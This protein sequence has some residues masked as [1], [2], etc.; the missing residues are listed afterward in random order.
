MTG[1][2]RRTQSG[3]PGTGSAFK[4]IDGGKNHSVNVEGAV[5]SIRP[6]KARR[7]SIVDYRQRLLDTLRRQSKS[8][9]YGWFRPDH[10][11]EL[12]DLALHAAA[13]RRGRFVWFG[14]I[15]FPMRFGI[16]K[17]VCDPETD[18]ILVAASGGW[19]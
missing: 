4:V 9:G 15:R 1:P 10:A 12:H 19:L 3:L 14:G 18:E 5:K 6:V 16:W 11:P 2:E 7:R 17:Y 13:V 8:I